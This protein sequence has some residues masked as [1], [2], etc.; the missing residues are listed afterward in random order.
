MPIIMGAIGIGAPIVGGIAGNLA[1]ADDRE[2]ARKAQEAALA[3]ILG[4][5]VPDI[6][7]QQITL[8]HLR[9]AGQLTPAMEEAILQQQSEMQGIS[10]DPRLKEAQMKALSQ[11]QQMGETPLTAVETAELNN[12]RRSTSQQAQARQESILQNM[13]QRGMG[14]SGSE[15]AAALSS[16]QAS[17]DRASQEGDRTAAMA[18]QRALEAIAGAGR[19][20]GQMRDQDFSEQARI[21][22]AQDA[23]NHFN[24]MQRSGVQTRNVS[25]TNDSRRHNLDNDQRISDANTGLTNK[26]QV[27]NKELIAKQY[28]MEMEKRRAAAAALTGQAKNHQDEGARE[29]KMY[30]DIGSGIGSGAMAFAAKK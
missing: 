17:A 20:G 2:A 30:T 5:T 28:E 10:T 25:A 26:Q 4:I 27:Y 14:G 29:S 11:L 1:G 12:I 13:A 16:S 15:L 21:A 8:E 18:Q 9:S 3:Q 23:I 22:Q 19:M 6:K 24:T 7:D